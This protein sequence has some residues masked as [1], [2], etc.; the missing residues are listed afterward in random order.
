MG[1]EGDPDVNAQLAALATG[2]A[3][4]QT[5]VTQLVSAVSE[6][7]ADTA[8]RIDAIAD[9]AT[10]DARARGARDDA[11]AAPAAAGLTPLVEA[12]EKLSQ[13]AVKEVHGQ[14][15][16]PFDFMYTDPPLGEHFSLP[17]EPYHMPDQATIIKNEVHL[18]KT[19]QR[20]S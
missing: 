13:P 17:S 5:A 18:F 10:T 4:L 20:R 8:R 16:R 7:V 1:D 3:G 2:L 6:N 9:D 11:A 14:A 19:T 15:I 12:I